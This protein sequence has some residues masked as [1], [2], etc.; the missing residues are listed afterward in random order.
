[1][2]KIPYKSIYKNVIVMKKAFNI[3]KPI[4]AYWLTVLI[5]FTL[6]FFEVF[7]VFGGDSP[8]L[9][10]VIFFIVLFSILTILIGYFEKTKIA[11]GGLFLLE[12][13]LITSSLLQMFYFYPNKELNILDHIITYSN[14]IFG[15]FFTNHNIFNAVL[16]MVFPLVTITIGVG[17]AKILKN[18]NYH[19]ECK[20][21]EDDRK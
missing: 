15:A 13:Q 2:L 10:S 9:Q 11:F 16:S 6:S 14:I 21:S 3:L 12:L 5:F 17:A 18:N 4:F 7:G 1:M 20:T 19:F 8:W